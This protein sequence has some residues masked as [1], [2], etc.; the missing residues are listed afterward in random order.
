MMTWITAIAGRIPQEQMSVVERVARALFENNDN[1]RYSWDECGD[2]PAYLSDAKAALRSLLTPELVEMAGKATD[3]LDSDLMRY[4]HGGG[5]WAKLR[6]GERK[7][8]ADFYNEADREFIVSAALTIRQ[9]ISEAT[10]S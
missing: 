6:D 1:G 10:P 5:R 3:A 8:V 7:L 9:I 2:K 4:E